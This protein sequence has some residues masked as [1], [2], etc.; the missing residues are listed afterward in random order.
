VYGQFVSP[1][2]FTALGSPAQGR[3]FDAAPTRRGSLVA[4]TWSSSGSYRQSKLSAGDAADVR[5]ASTTGR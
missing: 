1:N 5:S 4:M 3:F 2:Y